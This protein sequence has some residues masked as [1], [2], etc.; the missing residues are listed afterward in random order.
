[1]TNKYEDFAESFVYYILFNDDF[2]QKASLNVILQ[3]KY[4]FF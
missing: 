3:Q 4:D 1:M 2:R